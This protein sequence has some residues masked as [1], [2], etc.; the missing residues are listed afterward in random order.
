MTDKRCGAKTR[1][2]EPCKNRA[3]RGSN[4]CRM[5]G[6]TQPKGAASPNFKHGRHSSQL[7]QALAERYRTAHDDPI[8]LEQRDE[9]ALLDA[10]L[11]AL[12]SELDTGVSFELWQDA[13]AAVMELNAAQVSG[14]ESRTASAIQALES[15]LNDRAPDSEIWPEIYEIVEH[16]RKFV[17]SERKRFV[18]LQHTVPLSQLL[19]MIGQIAA[20][21]R[22]C[23]GDHPEEFKRFAHELYLL[24]GSDSDGE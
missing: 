4:R 8:M 1:T 14:D 22:Q 3:V 20:L 12:L 15:I 18:E 16:R 24:T 2:G 23:F 10:R 17:E 13:Q 7:P 9:I 11:A 21:A 19:T 5:H 6:G